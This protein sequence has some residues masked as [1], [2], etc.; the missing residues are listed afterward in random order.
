MKL[1]KKE[2]EHIAKLA[3]I[4]LTEQEKEKFSKELSKI[5]DYI[6]ILNELDTNDVKPKIQVTETFNEGRE[7]KI[8]KFEEISALLKSAPKVE[9]NFIKTHKIK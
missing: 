3:K 8:I 6:N 7:D 2:V 4:K 1:S 5:L 9:N